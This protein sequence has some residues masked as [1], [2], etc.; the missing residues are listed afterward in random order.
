MDPLMLAGAILGNI[1]GAKAAQALGGGDSSQPDIGAQITEMVNKQNGILQDYL[2]HAMERASNQFGQAVQGQQTQLATGTN[3][4]IS[5]L[6]S[7]NTA[8]QSNANQAMTYAPIYNQPTITAGNNA[9]D[10][11]SDAL[12]I[13]RSVVGSN[14]VQSAKLNQN[15]YNLGVG[16]L[17]SK[18]SDP[19]Q[20]TQAAPSTDV[21]TYTPT[22]DQINQYVRSHLSTVSLDKDGGLGTGGATQHYYTGGGSPGPQA[23]PDSLQRAGMLV[24]AAVP[25]NVM[26]AATPTVQNNLMQQAQQDYAQAQQQYNTNLQNYNTYNTNVSNLSNQYGMGSG[27]MTSSILAALNAGMMGGVQ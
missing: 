26:R 4:L 9:L 19:G 14:A 6:N 24:E 12:G 7:A 15:Q 5:Y 3:Q 27:T 18:P 16:A 21:N 25:Q 10:Y 23:G 22:Q 2:N 13:P 1:G 8:A 17:G 20:F 11:L